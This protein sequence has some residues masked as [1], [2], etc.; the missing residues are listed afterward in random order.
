MGDNPNVK[1]VT[2]TLMDAYYMVD[3]SS[4]VGAKAG[5]W[6]I[7]P[8]FEYWNAKFG[9]PAYRT[10]ANTPGGNVVNPTTTALMAAIEYHF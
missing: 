10:W 5:T 8:G 9:D 3:F 1:T 6:Q 7:G 4:L 2:E